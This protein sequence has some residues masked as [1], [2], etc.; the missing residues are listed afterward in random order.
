MK[1]PTAAHHRPPGATWPGVCSASGEPLATP[2]WWRQGL[3][4]QS[5]M[6][7]SS[8]PAPPPSGLRLL[9]MPKVRGPGPRRTP[10]G[11]ADPGLFPVPLPSQAGMGTPHSPAARSQCSLP[12]QHHFFWWPQRGGS[13]EHTGE[14][15]PLGSPQRW[16]GLR[17]A[18]SISQEHRSARKRQRPICQPAQQNRCLQLQLHGPESAPRTTAP[19]PGQAALPGPGATRSHLRA[20]RTGAWGS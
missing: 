17:T 19:G 18:W 15:I 5:P 10:A 14:T 20:G 2:L 8:C 3:P 16:H 6:S 4:V 7:S 11:A 9:P 13:Q 1:T 12:L